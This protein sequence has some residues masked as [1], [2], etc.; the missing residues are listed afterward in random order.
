VG[1]AYVNA[2]TQ[3]NA[4]LYVTTAAGVI[5]IVCALAGWRFL[6]SPP[7]TPTESSFIT[8]PFRTCEF[9]G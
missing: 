5:C 9:S 6:P 1:L 2:D 4:G 7:S 8:L 3:I